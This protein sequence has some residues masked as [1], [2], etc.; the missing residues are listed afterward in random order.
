[1]LQ[2]NYP[3]IVYDCSKIPNEIKCL[4]CGEKMII[5]TPAR[6]STFKVL[7]DKFASCHMHQK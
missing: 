4:I 5:T 6:Y 1:M 7:G 2:T 3:W